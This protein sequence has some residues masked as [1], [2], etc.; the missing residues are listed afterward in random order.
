M[1]FE[2]GY[3]GYSDYGLMSTAPRQSSDTSWPVP[4]SAGIPRSVMQDLLV[5]PFNDIDAVARLVQEYKDAIAAVFL[6]PFQ[7]LI[8]PQPGFLEALRELTQAHNILLVF[9]EVVTGSLRLGRRAGILWRDAGHLYPGQGDW[10]RFSA[11]RHRRQGRGHGAFLLL[12]YRARSVCA[13]GG[14]AVW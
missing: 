8:P 9:D 13:A 10:R 1:K 12:A 14:Y 5:A 6:E 7:R 2:G 3:H 11:G 4:D